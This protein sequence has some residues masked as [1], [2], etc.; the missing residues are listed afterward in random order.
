MHMALLKT[1][2][3]RRFANTVAI[4]ATAL[5]LMT[6]ASAVPARADMRGDDYARAIAA[7]AVIGIIGAAINDNKRDDRSTAK[8]HDTRPRVYHDRDQRDDRRNDRREDRREDRRATVLPQDCA[9]EIRGN[10]HNSTVYLERCLR[11]S[12]IDKRLPNACALDVKMRGRIVTAYR[13]NC[14][15]RAGFRTRGYRGH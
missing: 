7:L 4:A 6:A 13:E 5:A 8:A 3:F 10:R 2:P 1:T 14:L 11:R 15:E 12:G 9:V